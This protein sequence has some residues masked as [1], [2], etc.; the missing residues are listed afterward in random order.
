MQL[1]CMT[2]SHQ[3]KVKE[4][5]LKEFMEQ[6]LENKDKQLDKLVPR[7]KELEQK[8]A[9]LKQQQLQT[10]AENERLNI[11][12]RKQRKNKLHLDTIISYAVVH[13]L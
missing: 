6:Q 5:R 4:Q 10:R 11:I 3:E 13:L 2:A 9:E 12:N 1:F 8:L 7:Q